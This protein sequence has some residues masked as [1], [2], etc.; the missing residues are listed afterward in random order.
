V[1]PVVPWGELA[2]VTASIVVLTGR[3]HQADIAAALVGG[4]LPVDTPVTL[5]H[6]ASRP[7]QRSASCRLEQL[8]ERHLPAPATFV[9]GPSIDGLGEG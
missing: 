7:T 8:G 5:I 9:V 2:D 1:A 3:S 6:G 4:G